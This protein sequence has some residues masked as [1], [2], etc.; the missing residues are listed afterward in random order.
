[1]KKIYT[2]LGYFIKEFPTT[3]TAHDQCHRWNQ[4]ADHILYVVK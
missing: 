1:M 4:I 3:D 2:I